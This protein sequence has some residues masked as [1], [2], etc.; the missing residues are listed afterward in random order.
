M[1][2]ATNLINT[3]SLT[4]DDERAKVNPHDFQK[5]EC[6]NYLKRKKKEK[7]LLLGGK[8][9]SKSIDSHEN[10][11]KMDPMTQC[12]QRMKNG[13]GPHSSLVVGYAFS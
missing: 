6:N 11:Q 5:F 12:I 4:D 13:Y 1:E 8:S 3:T 7:L 2:Q 10:Q 9:L